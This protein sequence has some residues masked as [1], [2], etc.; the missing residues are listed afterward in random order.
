ML[1]ISCCFSFVAK[2]FQ[3]PTNCFKN[4]ILDITINYYFNLRVIDFNGSF[5]DDCRDKEKD[6]ILNLYVK[7]IITIFKFCHNYKLNV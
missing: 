5:Y 2:L 3:K 7:Y 4:I 1:K 6:R